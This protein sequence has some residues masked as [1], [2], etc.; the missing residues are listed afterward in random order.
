M[1][2]QLVGE[3]GG[4][5]GLEGKLVEPLAPGTVKVE[6]SDAGIGGGTEFGAGFTR[7]MFSQSSSPMTASS[8]PD[9][10]TLS[11]R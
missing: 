9:I 2:V 7:K 10:R 8:R 11:S 4:P 5:G 3:G 6:C 1:S